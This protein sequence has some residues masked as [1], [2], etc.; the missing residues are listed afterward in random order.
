[1]EGTF[2]WADGTPLSYTRWASGYPI[3]STDPNY[4]DYVY[5]NT[6]GFWYNSDHV[7]TTREGI[8]E[9]VG[10]ADSDGDGIP[11]VIDW[12]PLD[13]LNGLEIRAAGADGTFDTADDLVYDPRATYDGGTGVSVTIAD[14]P[15]PPGEYRLRIT[16]SVTDLVGNPL[17]GD[18]DGVPGGDFDQFFT[19]DPCRT[20]R[21]WKEP[22]T[23]AW[24][25]PR[26]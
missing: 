25:V 23:A 5:L 26:R 18:R 12:R 14:G 3:T 8:V 2:A 6:N 1:V 22:S 7:T 16:D 4:Y 20:E 11:D 9:F 13:A 10:D 19:I 17:D 21:C 24:R 15:L